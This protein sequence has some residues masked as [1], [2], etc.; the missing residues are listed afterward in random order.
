MAIVSVVAQFDVHPVDWY[1]H[2][3][4]FWERQGIQVV[5]PQ[6]GQEKVLALAKHMQELQPID[7]SPMD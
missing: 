5:G 1:N 2:R 4:E 3:M 6:L 7:L